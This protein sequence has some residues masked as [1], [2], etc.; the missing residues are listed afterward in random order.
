[1]VVVFP[2]SM[3]AMI[4][5]LRYMPRSTSRPTAVLWREVEGEWE[6][7]APKVGEKALDPTRRVDNRRSFILDG[8]RMVQGEWS[9]LGIVIGLDLIVMDLELFGYADEWTYNVLTRDIRGY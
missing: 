8:T 6:K 3:C 7:R 4:P 9:G 2:A 5:M 1:M